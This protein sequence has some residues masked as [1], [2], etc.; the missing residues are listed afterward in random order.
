[1]CDA[2]F[3]PNHWWHQFEQPFEQTASLN[4]WSYEAPD[5]PPVSLRDKRMRGI[6]IQNFMEAKMVELFKNKAR[7]GVGSER[8]SFDCS[9]QWA[10]IRKEMLTEENKVPL[11]LAA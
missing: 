3:L 11:S 8:V 9:N 5:T 2:R 4:V 6:A 7:A 1:L 10:Q